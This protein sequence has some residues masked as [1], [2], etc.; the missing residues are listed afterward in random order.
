MP[1]SSARR[2]SSAA[3]NAATSGIRPHSA[4]S[5][6]TA[7]SAGAVD[8]AAT[9]PKKSSLWAGNAGGAGEAAKP[10]LLKKF[11]KAAVK[12]TKTKR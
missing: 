3:S 10:L 1:V 4:L 9:T 5:S 7:S 12:V 11:V 6:I 2:R 8:K